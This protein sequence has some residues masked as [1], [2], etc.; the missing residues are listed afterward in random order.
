[1]RTSVEVVARRDARGRTVLPVVRASGQLAVRRTGEASV[2]LVA[3]A[4]GPLGGDDAEIRLVVEEGARLSVHSVAA[5]VVLPAR[6]ESPPSRQVV[7][8]EVA[9]VLELAPEPTVVTA[10]AVHLAELHVDLAETGAL[11]ATEQVLLGR[12]GEAPGRW[13]GTTRI[14]RAG[15]PMLHT[16]VGLGPGAPAWLPPLRPRAYVSTV[17]VGAGAAEV[18]TGEGAVRLPLPG[19]WVG[20]AWAEELHEAVDRLA[21]VTSGAVLAGVR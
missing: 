14:E 9:G 20:T 12:T 11:T 4:F 13:T 7:R 21:A 8:A 3:T 16:T 5:A 19:G 1:M 6:G 2:H 18:R 15:R 17:A 10:R